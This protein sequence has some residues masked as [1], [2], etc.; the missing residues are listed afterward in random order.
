MLY[1]KAGQP[2]TSTLA[3]YILPGP[4]ELPGF[5]LGHSESPSPYT[6]H[7]IKGVGEGAAIAPSGALVNAINDALSGY[8]AEITQ[9]PATPRRIL[10]ALFEAKQTSGLDAAE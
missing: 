9:I 10:E 4:A 1:D 8:G 6:R 5:R 3:D 7:G 2:L